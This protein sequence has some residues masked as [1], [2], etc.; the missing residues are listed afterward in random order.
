MFLKEEEL[1]QN[2]FHD[3]VSCQEAF[4]EPLVMEP[5]YKD[6]T[7]RFCWNS[8]S[9]EG[10][11]LSLDETIEVVDFDT[12][13]SGHT[14]REYTEAKNLYR[15]IQEFLDVEGTNITEEWVKHVNGKILG[16]EADYRKKNL[17]IGT[18]AEATYYPPAY[19][20][21]PGLMEEY[22]ANL[23]FRERTGEIS[24]EKIKQLAE[25]HIRFERIHPFRDGNGRTGRMILNQQL[26][27]AGLLP[28]LVTDQSKYRQAFRRYDKGGDVSM[29]V[30]LI[31]KGEQQSLDT[32]KK[33][34]ET[35]QEK[36]LYQGDGYGLDRLEQSE[37]GAG[38]ASAGA[39]GAILQRHPTV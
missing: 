34:R 30:Y 31:G 23:S 24:Y 12:V 22:L 28:I 7:Y 2:V 32:I 19:E 39:E 3:L 29:M 5:F 10:N 26:L 8:N 33:L 9:I 37:G 1:I 14:Y 17:Y 38:S 21:V 15:A 35:V 36:G 4:S 27:N 18:L 16:E 20:R 6:F 13:R 11:T 25:E